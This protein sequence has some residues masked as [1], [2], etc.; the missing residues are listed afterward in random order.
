MKQPATNTASLAAFIERHP[1]LFVLTGAGVSAPSGLP[2]YRD[3]RGQWLYRRPIQHNEFLQQEH[4]R[5]RYW[6]RSM[7]G[8]P[9]VRDAKPNNAHKALARLEREKKIVLLVTQNVDRLHQRASSRRVIDLHGRLDRV[10]CLDCGDLLEREGL[11]EQLKAANEQAWSESSR[12]RPDGD[13]DIPDSALEQFRVPACQHCDGILKPDVVFFGGNVPRARLQSCVSA[14][15]QS[16]ALVAVGTSL[17]VYSG[18]RFCRLA[19]KQGKPIAII[20][21]GHTRADNL[22]CLKLECSAQSALQALDI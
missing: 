16:D 19:A 2:T 12:Q 4:T 7:L 6:A 10:R 20:N 3:E 17:Q 18:F 15:E 8:W 11:Q 21:P 22:A 13:R 1:R 5:K 14:L 9:A